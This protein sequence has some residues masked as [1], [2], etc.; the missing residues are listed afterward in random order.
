MKNS[1][2]INIRNF[3]GVADN[4]SS[5]LFSG[6]TGN[7]SGKSKRRKNKPLP[8]NALKFFALSLKSI[9]EEEKSEVSYN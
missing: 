1:S 6:Q 5:S 8:F 2:T 7:K 4:D 9:R 3:G